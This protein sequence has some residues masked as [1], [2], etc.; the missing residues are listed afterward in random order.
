VTYT[1]HRLFVFRMNLSITN[2]AL[3]DRFNIVYDP[4][5]KHV[6]I[7]LT[8]HLFTWWRIW[9]LYLS[10]NWSHGM[11]ILSYDQKYISFNY[12]LY[13]I[14]CVFLCL[15]VYSRLSNFSA[16]RR[17]AVTIT[18]D[19]TANLDLSVALMAFSSEGCSSCHTYCDTGPW[20][21]RSHLKDRHPRPTMDSNRGRNDHKICAPPL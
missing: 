17:A 10:F 8:W 18:G 9:A 12:A 15:F 20:F 21:I 16:I 6:V 5:W 13:K 19:G 4:H 11:D 2:L 3:N 7:W 14:I 1:R